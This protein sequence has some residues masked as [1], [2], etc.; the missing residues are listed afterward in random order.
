M[1]SLLPWILFGI[2]IT[3]PLWGRLLLTVFTRTRYEQPLMYITYTFLAVCG[4]TLLHLIWD[5][6]IYLGGLLIGFAI[7]VAVILAFG[8]IFS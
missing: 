6:L 8:D 7:I 4:F 1:N 5:E 2:V 3:F